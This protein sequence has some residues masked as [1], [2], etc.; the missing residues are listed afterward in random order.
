MVLCGLYKIVVRKVSK[1]DKGLKVLKK[2]NSAGYEAYVVGGAVRDYLLNNEISDID[3]TTNAKIAEI[4]LIFDNVDLK[5]NDYAGITIYYDNEPFEI[6]SFRKD[7]SYNDHRHPVVELVNN[8][9]EDLIRRDFSMNAL[10]MDEN[11]NI[12]DLFSGIKSINEKIIYTIGDSKVRF[13][14]DSLRVLRAV[15]F[16]GKLGFRL[17]EEIINTIVSFDYVAYLPKEYIKLMLDKIFDLPNR[18]GINILSKYKVLRGFPFYQVVVDECIKYKVG[19]NDMYALFYVLHGF[20]PENERITKEE[21]KYAKCVADLVRNKFNAVSLFNSKGLLLNEAQNL[22]NIIYDEKINNV[23]EDYNNL[24]IHS[25]K[26]IKYDF[27]VVFNKDR[28]KV[29]KEVMELILNG[30]LENSCDGIAKIVDLRR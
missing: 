27:N 28:S 20:L 11:K 29:Q 13:N 8:L 30:V 10:A 25:I 7:V 15:Y 12:I 16:S 2:L 23:V 24:P 1:L 18:S 19:K 14:E 22:Y 26:D 3:I 9:E 17:S 5:A 6:T 21:R 4:N